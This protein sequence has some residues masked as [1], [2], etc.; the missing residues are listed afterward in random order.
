ML[1]LAE[2][3]VTTHRTRGAFSRAHTSPTDPDLPK[4]ITS[5]HGQ[6]YDWQSLEAIR[7][8][9]AP[10]SRS[11]KM[12]DFGHGTKLFLLADYSIKPQPQGKI[13]KW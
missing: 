3:Q 2:R 8:E 6:G 12:A 11:Q 10:G 5:S 9:L 1:L 4:F 13:L 7:L